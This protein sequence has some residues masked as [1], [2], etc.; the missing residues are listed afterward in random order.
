MVSSSVIKFLFQMLSNGAR[1]LYKKTTFSLLRFI[2]QVTSTSYLQRR[3]M[4]TEKSIAEKFQLPKR[5]KGSEPSV[6]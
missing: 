3:N 4:S 5:Y 1:D 6:W 2:P